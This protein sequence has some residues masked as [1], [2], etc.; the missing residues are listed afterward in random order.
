M[1]YFIGGLIIGF[2]IGIYCGVKLA[3][4]AIKQ[5]IK[6]AKILERFEEYTK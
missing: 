4:W 6:R 1:N 5:R 2:M 3:G